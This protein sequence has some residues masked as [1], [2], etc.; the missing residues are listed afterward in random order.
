MDLFA[1]EKSLMITHRKV[2]KIQIIKGT[3]LVAQICNKCGGT[4]AVISVVAPGQ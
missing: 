3:S 2:Y 4:W 1:S